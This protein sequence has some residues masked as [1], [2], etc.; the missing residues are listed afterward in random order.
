M[1]EVKFDFFFYSEVK[2]DN[3]TTAKKFS[4]HTSEFNENP[5]FDCFRFFSF[6]STSFLFLC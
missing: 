4:L 5:V 1:K 6:F 2:V 3:F